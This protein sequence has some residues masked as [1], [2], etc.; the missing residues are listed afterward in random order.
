[1]AGLLAVLYG[2]GSYTLGSAA[3]A[4]SIGFV[5]NLGVPKS[6]DSGAAG[7]PLPSAL[8]DVALLG[9]FAAQHSVMA[10]KGF[11][12]WWTRFVPRPIER[13]TYVL[14]SG[15]ALGLLFWQW[16]PLP[17]AMWT[18]RAPFAVLVLHAVFWLG[19]SMLFLSTCLLSHFELFGV[20]QVFA[21][22]ARKELPAPRFHTPLLYRVVR[23]P[24]YL[25]LLLAFWS[26]PAMTAGHLLFALATTGYILL[27]IQLEER[28]LI[29]LFGNQYRRYRREVGMLIPWPRR[30]GV[31][32]RDGELAPR[33]GELALRNRELALLDVTLFDEGSIR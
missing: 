16:R 7:P 5:G 26:T 1:M 24:I 20:R 19:W 32:P 8:V 30:R 23:H 15:A 9:L 6:I 31:E 18:V 2:I 33:N 3:L 14:F 4:Y 27:G 28:D 29:G 25:S 10:R 17:D 22:R 21:Y 11:K 13:S 12:Q